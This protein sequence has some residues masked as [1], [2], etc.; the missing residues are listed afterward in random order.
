MPHGILMSGFLYFRQPVRILPFFGQTSPVFP[1]AKGN[2]L[3]R[4]RWGRFIH[5]AE[6]KDWAV[7]APGE[8]FSSTYENWKK[9]CKNETL[10]DKVQD[11]IKSECPDWAGWNE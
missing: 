3:C 9:I 1:E 2:V 6:Y 8:Y 11:F 5:I 10:K 7:N 4:N